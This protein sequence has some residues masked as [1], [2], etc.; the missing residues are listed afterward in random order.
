MP[1]CFNTD[2]GS[3]KHDGFN[4]VKPVPQCTLS[5]SDNKRSTVYD[6]LLDPNLNPSLSA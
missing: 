2:E 3:N 5:L 6:V 4:D 1:H